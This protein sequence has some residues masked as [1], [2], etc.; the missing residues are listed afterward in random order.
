MGDMRADGFIFQCYQKR[1]LKSGKI[2]FRQQWRSPE[3]MAKYRVN[4]RQAQRNW[5]QKKKATR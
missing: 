5:Y 1:R 3:A 4:N 2:V